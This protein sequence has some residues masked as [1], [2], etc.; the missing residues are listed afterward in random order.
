MLKRKKSSGMLEST[1]DRAAK[2]DDHN[3]MVASARERIS[4]S[5]MRQAGHVAGGNGMALFVNTRE[6]PSFGGRSNS[7]GP[8]NDFAI[9][10][11]TT[12]ALAS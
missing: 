12:S 2:N 4:L 7:L 6:R 8:L 3:E 5:V 10:S 9:P 11:N 1:S